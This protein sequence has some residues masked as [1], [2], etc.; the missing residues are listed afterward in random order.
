M[1]K[2]VTIV[3]KQCTN[4]F[5]IIMSVK[6]VLTL[7]LSQFITFHSILLNF[8]LNIIKKINIITILK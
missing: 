5:L 6:Y 1:L 4:I 2:Y 7:L 8:I 3:K